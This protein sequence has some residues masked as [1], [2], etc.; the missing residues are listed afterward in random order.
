MAGGKTRM[1]R[2][3]VRA[4]FGL[5]AGVACLAALPS[6]L[7]A[8]SGDT[9]RIDSGLSLA[10]SGDL[11]AFTPASVDPKLLDTLRRATIARG[12][13]SSSLF[14][15]TPAGSRQSGKRSVT[16]AV[17]VDAATAKSVKSQKG[18]DGIRGMAGVDSVAFNLGVARGYQSFTQNNAPA[19][20]AGTRSFTLPNEIGEDTA[21]DLRSFTPAK[22]ASSGKSR[23]ST[24]VELDE[25]A[26]PGSAPR[27]FADG[28]KSVDVGGAYRVAGNLKVTA[29]IR[30]SSDRDRLAPLTD[31]QQDNQSVYVGT[32][33]RF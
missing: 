7:A 18:T 15:F 12:G 27:T 14:R 16:L 29:G 30:Y 10:A 24:T 23:F 13:D 25:N 2:R 3:K 1:Q 4:G 8:V 17:R 31:G 6:A 20:Q 11:G 32:R 21:P 22:S 33:F 5:C 9:L 28:E 26:L 19:V